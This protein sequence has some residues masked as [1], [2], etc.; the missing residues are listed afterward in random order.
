[1]AKD[2]SQ[3]QWHGDPRQPRLDELKRVVADNHLV[4]VD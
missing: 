3:A 1:M 4:W 2:L